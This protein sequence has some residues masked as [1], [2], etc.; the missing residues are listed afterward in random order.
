MLAS[1]TRFQ[2]QERAILGILG[3]NSRG[4]AN[5]AGGKAQLILETRQKP[6]RG[7]RQAGDHGCRN[8]G[9]FADSAGREVA[10][11]VGEIIEIVPPEK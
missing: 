8:F 5:K 1:P 11:C 2:A 7:G 4:R 6:G 10:T 9:Y 3:E